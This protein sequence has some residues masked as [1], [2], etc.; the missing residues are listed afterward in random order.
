LSKRI[1]SSGLS[2]YG[3]ERSKSEKVIKNMRGGETEAKEEDES[4]ENK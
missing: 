4:D 1:V 3:K 2:T